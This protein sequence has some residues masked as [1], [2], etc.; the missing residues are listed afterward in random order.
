MNKPGNIPSSEYLREKAEELL[1]MRP[2]KQGSPGSEADII[3]LI[4]ELEV[5]QIELEMVNEELVRARVVSEESAEKF[6]ELYDFAPTGYFTLSAEGKIIGMNLVGAGKFGTER[7][8]LINKHFDSFVSDESKPVF[9]LF[10]E[11]VFHGKLKENCELKLGVPGHLPTYVLLAGIIAENQNQCNLTM[12]DITDRKLIEEKLI[13]SESEFRFLAEAM[14][15][16]VWITDKNGSNTYFNQKWVDYTGLT[17]EKSYGDGWNK[18][19]HPD[20]QKRAWDAWQNATI[21]NATYSLECRL[22]RSD[23]VYKW[24]LIRGVPVMDPSGN[25]LKW[26]GTCTDID[27]LKNSEADLIEAKEHAE[28]SNRLKTALLNNISHEIRTPLNGILGFAG[29]LKEP[30]FTDEEQQK[31]IRIIEKSG[32]RLLRT[33]TD[34]IEISTISSG[35]AELVLSVTDLDELIRDIHATFLPEAEKKGLQLILNCTL[36][37]GKA[38]VSTDNG[39][40]QTILYHLVRNAIRFTHTGSVEVG[41]LIN[42]KNLEFFVK[43]TGIGIPVHQKEIIFEPFRQGDD[44]DTR[45]YEG[46]GLGLSVSRAYVEMLDGKIWLDTEV[47][48]GTI[49]YFTLPYTPEPDKKDQ[50]CGTSGGEDEN[51]FNNMKILIAED[52]EATVF[53][54]TMALRD[55][56]Q[57]IFKVRT[58]IEA[59][60]LCRKNPDIDLVLMDLRMPG[61][62]GEEAARQIR[63]FNKE[64]VIIA[65]TAYGQPVDK[66]L[67]PEAG[68]NDFI[69]KPFTQES[70]LELVSLHLSGRK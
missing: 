39:K 21:N 8:N 48:K 55:R 34:I 10:L 2:L 26:F 61:L 37:K 19:F 49:F 35:Q 5:H 16:I 68:F 36:P 45:I 28:E 65:Q 43:D 18:P 51:I 52:D 23:G 54:I 60:E 40:L 69:S 38:R 50:P 58:G 15:Q 13:K 47:G 63:Q 59:V 14:P 44:S 70:L 33:I 25:I 27:E 41:C 6:V 22:R 7:S 24:W 66:N 57:E 56:C 32:D 67:L 11:K 20:D 3:R 64:V 1:K 9:Y 4:H 12:I 42:G 31:F 46:A 17:L 53:F 62:N 29:L 30:H